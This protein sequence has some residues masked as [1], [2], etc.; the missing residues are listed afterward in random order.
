M[1]CVERKFAHSLRFV[2]PRM[3][4]P[5][6]RSRST[7][8]A[9]RGAFAPTSASEPAVVCIRSRGGDVVLDQHRDAVER[10]GDLP[11]LR[12]ASRASATVSASGLISITACK[13]PLRALMRAI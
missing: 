12:S 8:N 5:A 11:R 1:E 13:A 3:T 7:M 9:S 6:A 10:A 4:A 2:L